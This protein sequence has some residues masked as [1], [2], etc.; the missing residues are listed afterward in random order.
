MTAN[1]T[2]TVEQAS[3]HVYEALTHHFGPMDLS[4]KQPLVRAISEYGQR[5]RE[6]D[7]DRIK[8]AS[9]HIWQELSHHSERLD[10]GAH[11]PLV[12]ALA[13]YG[14]ACRRAGKAA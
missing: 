7:E 11:D 2:L 4:A 3:T 10:L 6:G 8:E 1:S 13:E 9:A 14:Q 5:C 12:K